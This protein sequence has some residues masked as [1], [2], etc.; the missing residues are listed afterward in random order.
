MAE[1]RQTNGQ[2]KKS[3]RLK[4]N[5]HPRF[6]DDLLDDEFDEDTEKLIDEAA[7]KWPYKS[8]RSSQS[9]SSS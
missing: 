7:L 6:D 8:R 9:S 4:H 3:K 1:P 5:H 2:W